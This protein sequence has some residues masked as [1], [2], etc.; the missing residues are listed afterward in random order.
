[1]E[2]LQA[3]WDAR[4]RDPQ[5]QTVELRILNRDPM[6]YH[7][8][9]LVVIYTTTLENNGSLFD[10]IPVDFER[11]DR[12]FYCFPASRIVDSPGRDISYSSD[13]GFVWARKRTFEPDARAICKETID[14][15]EKDRIFRRAHQ[16]KILFLALRLDTEHT[17]SPYQTFV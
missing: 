10:Q 1:M 17:R 4:L 15:R 12:I 5:A 11:W 6:Y 7:D 3:E 16:G 13:V 14:V 2:E 9:P 8:V